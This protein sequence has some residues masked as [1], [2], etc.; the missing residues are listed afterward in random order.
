MPN[1]QVFH[2]PASG[3]AS[4]GCSAIFLLIPA[5]GA[6]GTTYKQFGME[7][8]AIAVGCSLAVF[9]AIYAF[10]NEDSTVTLDAK[11]LRL[12]H[13]HWFLGFRGRTKVAWEIPAKALEEARE[14]KHFRPGK[15][16]GWQTSL[17]LHLPNSIVLEPAL[18]GGEHREGGAYRQLVAALEARLGAGFT[19]LDDF[20]PLGRKPAG[21]PPPSG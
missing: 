10:F 11:G 12:T 13:C 4:M 1:D 2:Q 14:I 3:F 16:G 18:L 5:L 15:G 19:R 6:V 17:K 20:G 7:G 8:A 9:L 21:G